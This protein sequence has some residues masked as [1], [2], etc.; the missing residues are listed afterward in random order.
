[1]GRGTVS[2]SHDG[3]RELIDTLAAKY[4]G[5]DRYTMDD[6][7]DNV[8]VTLRITPTGCRNALG[9]GPEPASTQRGTGPGPSRG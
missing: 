6:G 5:A 7:T 1:M 9:P 4:L 8:R 3:A 2:L